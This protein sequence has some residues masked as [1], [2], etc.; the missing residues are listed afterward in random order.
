M[1]IGI[2]DSGFGGLSVF[3]AIEKTLPEYNYVYLGDSAR[4]PYGNHSHEVISTY[5]QEA[6]EYLFTQ[7]D[8]QVVILACNTA[9]AQA[10][11]KLQQEW[12][13][14]NYPDRRVLGVIRPVAEKIAEIA[15]KKK[16]GVIGTRATIRSKVFTTE[17]EQQLKGEANVLEQA[18][19]LLVPIVEEGFHKRSE[20]KRILKH[21]LA[22][23]K[24]AQVDV[25][26][27]GCTHYQLMEDTIKKIMGKRVL[28]LDS[29]QVV[30]DSFADYLQR[31]T[32]I[33]T[34]LAKEGERLFLTTDDQVRFNQLASQFIGSPIKAINVSITT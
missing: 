21:Y 24:E 7:Y 15:P 27:N 31:H 30:A 3:K 22:P 6:V 32:E 34:V 18:C 2:F 14:Q 1:Q 13:P 12:L 11:R 26:I 25:L 19:P 20:T 10:L 9:S 8:C 16:I 28:V 23:L 5:V 29:P 17:I 33:E 4:A